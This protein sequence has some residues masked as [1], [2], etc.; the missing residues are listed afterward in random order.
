MILRSCT[1]LSGGRHN[2]VC[3][4]LKFLR[5]L[6]RGCSKAI[7]Y[8]V[9]LV[10]FT[11][12]VWDV[13]LSSTLT[14]PSNA[15]QANFSFCLAVSLKLKAIEKKKKKGEKKKHGEREKRKKEFEKDLVGTPKENCEFV[16]VFIDSCHCPVLLALGAGMLLLRSC[17]VVYGPEKVI[18]TA[19]GIFSSGLYE[20][21]N[22]LTHSLNSLSIYLSIFFF[23]DGVGVCLIGIDQ[24]KKSSHTF[25]ITVHVHSAVCS[26]CLTCR[27]VSLMPEK[28]GR[29]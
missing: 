17:V 12:I 14:K 10:K 15:S 6:F 5:W 1:W 20:S 21:P 11:T 18:Q 13:E 9:P 3:F 8:D 16:T 28:K 24:I 4:R 29:E 19:I 2:D 26:L 25:A 27:L 23:F 7:W 22:L